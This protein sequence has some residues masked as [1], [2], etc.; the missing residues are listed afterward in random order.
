MSDK[1]DPASPVGK[2]TRQPADPK[3]LPV[4]ID[5]PGLSAVEFAAIN[6]RVP[7]SGTPWLDKMIVEARRMDAAAVA[8]QALLLNGS[9]GKSLSE[10]STIDNYTAAAIAASDSMARQLSKPG[11]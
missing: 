8:M 11:K 5:S 1:Q 2:P 10:A 4:V 6:L 7:N 9:L 3:A